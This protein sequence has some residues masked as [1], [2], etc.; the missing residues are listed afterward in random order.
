MSAVPETMAAAPQAMTLRELSSIVIGRLSVAELRR[1]WIVAETSDVAVRSGHCYLELIERDPATAATLAKARATIWATTNRMLSA[2]FMAVTGR[3]LESG[4]RVLVN[5]SVDYHAVYGFKL[6]V[7]DI[8]PGYTVGDAV[9]RRREILERLER[10][11]VIDMNKQLAMPVPT[12]RIA[13]VSAPGAAGYGDFI[14][15]LN[16]NPLKLRFNVRLFEAVMQGERTAPT[17]MKALDAI[18]SSQDDW[19]CVVIIRGG[20]ASSDLE[21]FDNYELAAYVAQFPLPVIVGI[22]HERD[23]T[24]LDYIANVRVKTP[25]AAAEWLI[26]RGQEL[27]DNLRTLANSVLRIAADRV[28]GSAE[29]LSR[30]GGQ[31]ALAPGGAL[32]RAATRL[33]SRANALQAAG[34]AITALRSRRLAELEGSLRLLPAMLTGRASQRLESLASMV[35]VLSPAATLRR[36]YTITRVG[37]RALASVKDLAPGD[38]ITTVLADGTVNSI[39]K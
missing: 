15:Q 3:P 18:N 11:G 14:D 1:V 33:A 32:E 21:A 7:N 5:V 25:T 28:A 10:E 17:V 16:R 2:K 22:G 37:G 13:V 38:V 19:D 8:D 39:I 31:L 35:D 36:G 12:L 34:T 29:Q 20:G 4:M 24:V 26:A 30:L 27:I 23:V 6:I 9:R